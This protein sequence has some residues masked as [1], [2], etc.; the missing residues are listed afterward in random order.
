MN[1]DPLLWVSFTDQF[2]Y[3]L[4]IKN[5]NFFYNNLITPFKIFEIY[6]QEKRSYSFIKLRLSE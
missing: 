4:L 3:R 1:P 6:F 2:Y 5:N